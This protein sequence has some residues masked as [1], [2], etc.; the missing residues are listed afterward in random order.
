[1][2]LIVGLGNPGKKYDRSWHNLG[3]SAA[4]ELRRILDLPAFKKSIKFKAEVSAGSDGQEKLILAKPLTFMNNSG[5]SVSALASFYKIKPADIIIIHDDLDLPLGKIR[6]AADSSAGGHN[7]LKS[8]IEKL[9]TKNF[10]RV[11]I[12]IK[13]PGLEKIEA[14]DY[15]LTTPI[16]SDRIQVKEQIKKAAE[17]ARDLLA[18]GLAKSM[19]KWN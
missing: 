7:G 10:N 19:N 9:G 6:L 2:K 4:E 15:V 1:M 13:T 8:I 12:G 3:F 18:I 5:D 16:K 17:A 14:A 11:K